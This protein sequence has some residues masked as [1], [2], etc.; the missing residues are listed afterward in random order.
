MESSGHSGTEQTAA[1]RLGAHTDPTVFNALDDRRATIDIAAGV[2]FTRTS[3]QKKG[4]KLVRPPLNIAPRIGPRPNK[5]TVTD[6]TE[7][8]A[9]F[10]NVYLQ[11]N[12]QAGAGNLA[13]RTSAYANLGN[14]EAPAA[15]TAEPEA[16]RPFT[17]RVEAYRSLGAANRHIAT[18]KRRLPPESAR[19]YTPTVR[20]LKGLNDTKP[21]DRHTRAATK[22]QKKRL[23]DFNR[24]AFSTYP[25]EVLPSALQPPT[26]R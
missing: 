17:N 13:E 15:N 1:Q 14:Y 18:T 6:F 16:K 9:F 12:R 3:R 26:V 20:P 19:P 21:Q 23:G 10:D 22:G 4:T 8:Q 24:M 7:G 11:A 5:R 25:T 2:N